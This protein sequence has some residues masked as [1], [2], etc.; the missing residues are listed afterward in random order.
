MRFQLQAFA[1]LSLLSRAI[2]AAPPTP[3]GGPAGNPPA[4]I[5]CGGPPPPPPGPGHNSPPPPDHTSPR[6]PNTV[7]PKPPHH[8]PYPPGPRNKVCYVKTHND[9]S[10]DSTYILNALHECNNGGHVVFKEGYNYTI[11]TALDLTFLNHIDIGK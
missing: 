3:P 7:G 9:G 11:G 10:D 2:L 8:P 6:P 4:P 1:G 5:P